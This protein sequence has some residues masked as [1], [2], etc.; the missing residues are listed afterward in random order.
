MATDILLTIEGDFQ[1]KDGDFL[2]GYS[3]DMHIQHHLNAN[4]GNYL[5]HP[6]LG[7]GLTREKNGPVNRGEIATAIR[8][9]LVED[10]FNVRQVDVSGD[11]DNL[12]IDINAQLK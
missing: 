8:R 12:K 4:P 7:V 6:F 5:Q 10:G 9:S 1:F 3:D 11:F 2:T